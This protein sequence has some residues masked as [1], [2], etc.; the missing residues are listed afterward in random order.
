MKLWQLIT[1]SSP[2]GVCFPICLCIFIAGTTSWFMRSSPWCESRFSHIFIVCSISETMIIIP[3]NRSILSDVFEN[4]REIPRKA[5][6]GEFIFSISCQL[7]KFSG[8]LFQRTPFNR[9]FRF[10]DF[11]MKHTKLWWSS[12]VLTK[13]FWKFDGKIVADTNLYSITWG[14]MCK[15]LNSECFCILKTTSNTKIHELRCFW[16]PPETVV[17]ILLKHFRSSET[18]LNFRCFVL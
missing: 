7:L 3:F 10:N 5:T 9:C 11:S 17:D 15:C 13:W 2:V 1:N 4:F 8:R 6:A 14:W 12:A 18:V 16:T